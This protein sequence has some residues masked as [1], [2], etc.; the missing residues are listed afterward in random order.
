VGLQVPAQQ[1]RPDLIGQILCR[2]RLEHAFDRV[3][4]RCDVDTET[5]A[6]QAHRRQQ[7]LRRRGRP[8]RDPDQIHLSGQHGGRT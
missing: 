2:Q 1:V 8:R 6:A 7:V 3:R 4:V 5:V